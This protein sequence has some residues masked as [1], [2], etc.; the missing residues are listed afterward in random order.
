MLLKSSGLC[1][2]LAATKFIEVKIIKIDP[3]KEKVSLSVKE[4]GLNPVEQYGVDNPMG[5]T[6]KGIVRDI[7]DFG[8]FIR[9]APGVDALIRS[10]D[11]FPKTMEEI[12]IGEEIEAAISL[13]EPPKIRLS[14]RKLQRDKERTL[15]K[16]INNRNA[17]FNNAFR[18]KLRS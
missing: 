12:Q 7:K 3:D 13:F 9:L 11:L 18:E 1:D 6:V 8:A 10:E 15:I 2:S 17:G 16:D 4:L 5:S 14:Q